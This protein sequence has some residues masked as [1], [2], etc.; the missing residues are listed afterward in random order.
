MKNILSKKQIDRYSRQIVLKKVGILG[1]RKILE[2]KVLI[3][4][5]GCFC[6]T[7]DVS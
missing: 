6:C 5:S 7:V 3:V 2:S 4:G 1:Q